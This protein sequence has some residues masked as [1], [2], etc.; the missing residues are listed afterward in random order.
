[1]PRHWQNKFLSCELCWIKTIFKSYVNLC[2]NCK[3]ITSKMKWNNQQ[4]MKQDWDTSKQSI[5]EYEWNLWYHISNSWVTYNLKNMDVN[6]LSNVIK[7]YQW[8]EDTSSLERILQERMLSYNIS[9]PPSESTR[10]EIYWESIHESMPGISR[11]ETAN[12]TRRVDAV[13]DLASD[14]R[15]QGGMIF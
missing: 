10:Q 3:T 14:E 8:I 11:W 12:D 13:V 4:E 6:Y 7:R 1:M 5:K 15:P 9:T 2:D